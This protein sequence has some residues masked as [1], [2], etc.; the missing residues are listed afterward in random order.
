MRDE[1]EFVYFMTSSR[2]LFGCCLLTALYLGAVVTYL[3]TP[4]LI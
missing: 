1:E 2:C 3:S 4:R